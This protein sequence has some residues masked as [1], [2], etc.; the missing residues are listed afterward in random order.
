MALRTGGGSSS[1]PP[2]VSAH[3]LRHLSVRSITIPS[4]LAARCL[5]S[6]HSCVAGTTTKVGRFYLLLPDFLRALRRPTSCRPRHFSSPA[7]V[8][9]AIDSPCIPCSSSCPPRSFPSRRFSGPIIRR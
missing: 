2:L 8:S 6:F 7:F 1:L 9:C 3:F 5:P 4:L